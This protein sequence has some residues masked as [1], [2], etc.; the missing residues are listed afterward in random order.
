ME[1]IP[2]APETPEIP[3]IRYL[4]LYNKLCTLTDLL[5]CPSVNF[6]HFNILL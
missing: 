6:P 2:E 5:T 1:V 3:E 4:C